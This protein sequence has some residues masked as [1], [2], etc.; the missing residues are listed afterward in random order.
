VDVAGGVGV[1]LDV[2]VVVGA[3]VL[4]VLVVGVTRGVVVT[5]GVA[6]GVTAAGVIVAVG[7]AFTGAILGVG[8]VGKAE[9][10]NVVWV[11]VLFV[12]ADAP[13]VVETLQEVPALSTVVLSGLK[14]CAVVLPLPAAVLLVDDAVELSFQLA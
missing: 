2:A 4:G 6:V 13:R 5:L 9:E 14:W 7:V 1:T 11:D 8:V 3:G 12:G 10:G